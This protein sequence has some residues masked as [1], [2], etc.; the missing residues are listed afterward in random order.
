[1]VLGIELRASDSY[2]VFPSTFLLRLEVAHIFLQTGIN[3][4]PRNRSI[5]FTPDTIPAG[6]AALLTNY[7]ISLRYHLPW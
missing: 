6:E 4:G 7:W 5:T 2:I 3:Y 1:M